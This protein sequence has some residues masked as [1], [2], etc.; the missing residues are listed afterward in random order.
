MKPELIQPY[1]LVPEE[2]WE[3]NNFYTQSTW[4]FYGPIVVTL[5]PRQIAQNSNGKTA[6]RIKNWPKNVAKVIKKL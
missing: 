4:Q 3:K 2:V 1:G 6:K 5:E